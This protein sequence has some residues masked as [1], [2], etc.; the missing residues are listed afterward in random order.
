MPRQTTADT[1]HAVALVSCVLPRLGADVLSK[2][3]SSS[4]VKEPPVVGEADFEALD[5]LKVNKA[6]RGCTGS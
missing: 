3:V 6:E 5:R 2:G 4:G 1:H